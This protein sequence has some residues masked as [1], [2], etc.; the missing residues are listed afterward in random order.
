MIK[1]AVSLVHK[2]SKRLIDPM[3]EKLGLLDNSAILVTGGTGFFG[4]WICEHVNTLNTEFKKN[5]KLYVISRESDGFYI[6]LS[7]LNQENIV[8]IRSDVKNIT[9]LPSDVNY[10]IHAAG[11]PDNRYHT[12]NPMRTM[13]DIAEGTSALL[14][15]A[16]RLP[17]LRMFMYVSSSN[18]Y[19]QEGE[20]GKISETSS[21]HKIFGTISSA[22]AEAKRF[23][24]TLIT[25]ARSEIRLPVVTIRPFTF[26]GPYQPLDAPWAINNFINDAISKRPIRVLGNGETV[27]GFLYGGDFALWALVILCNTKSGQVYN[28]GSDES[29]RLD[30]LALRVSK[31]FSPSPEIIFN[32]SLVG[33]VPKTK[34]VADI[35]KVKTDFGLK[36]FTSIDEALEKSITWYKLSRSGE[37]NV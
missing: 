37:N 29:I 28:V 27:R 18:V 32:A 5:I 15:A 8:Y 3:L 26:V 10:I 17:N 33:N 23:A 21:G 30:D 20:E 31:N 36:V 6:N 11:S 16:D 25:A 13:M 12:S 22:Y 24:E 35:T 1:S 14:K 19:G 7:H 4:S 9:E 34:I 2:D